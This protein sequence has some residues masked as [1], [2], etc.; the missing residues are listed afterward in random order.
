MTEYEAASLVV[1]Q[2]MLEI[3]TASLTIQ[4]AQVGMSGLQT[5][6]IAGGLWMM[7]RASTLR[8]K[9]MDQQHE[10]SMLSLRTLIE[11]TAPQQS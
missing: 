4:W 9:Q 7:S 8:N 11:R 10:E 2:A 6:L 1:Q 5:L 3:Q